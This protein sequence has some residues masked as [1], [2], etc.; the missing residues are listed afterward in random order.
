MSHKEQKP[1]L[2]LKIKI[3]PFCKSQKIM[4]LPIYDDGIMYRR[5]GWKQGVVSYTQRGVKTSE[6]IKCS[7]CNQVIALDEYAGENARIERKVHPR[8]KFQEKVTTSTSSEQIVHQNQKIKEQKVQ[9]KSRCTHLKTLHADPNA[10]FCRECGKLTVVRKF[11]RKDSR[12]HVQ[13]EKL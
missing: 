7:N 6:I 10:L 3:C 9:K 5:H 4:R 1:D 8:A 11:L 12:K 2:S 13:I